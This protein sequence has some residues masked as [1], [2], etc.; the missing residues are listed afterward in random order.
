MARPRRIEFPGALYHSISRGDGRE[1]IDRV[2][3]DPRMLLG[4]LADVCERFQLV[5]ARLMSDDEPLPPDRLLCP[6]RSL[7]W[8]PS[9][10]RPKHLAMGAASG[11]E[12]FQSLS[13]PVTARMPLQERNQGT[14]QPPRDRTTGSRP[15]P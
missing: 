7:R 3:G 12:D 1:D 5:G 14:K 9:A 6:G 4:V 11:R 15:A 13:Q 2:E 8:I 10:A